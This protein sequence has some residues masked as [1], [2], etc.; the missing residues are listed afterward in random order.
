MIPMKKPIAALLVLIVLLAAASCAIIDTRSGA[1]VPKATTAAN[2]T[3]KT[4]T[5]THALG[6]VKVPYNPNKVVV[7]DL[8]VLDML[9][10][11][12]LGARVV[13]IPDITGDGYFAKYEDVQQLGTL[14]DIDTNA[15]KALKPELIVIGEA[16]H[17]KYEEL[18]EIAPVIYVSLDL[19]G[20]YTKALKANAFSIANIFGKALDTNAHLTELERRIDALAPGDKTALAV[21]LDGSAARLMDG[22]DGCV[23]F[24]REAGFAWPAEMADYESGGSNYL[25]TV[26]AVNPDYIFVVATEDAAAQK[27][28]FLASD[29]IKS[30]DAYQNSRII[31]LDPAAWHH[32]LGGITATKMMV[33]ELESL[34]KK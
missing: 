13:G 25:D 16:L 28:A 14:P 8:A 31:F 2:T 7:L 24:L 12:A 15:I 18:S 9:D 23:A 21:L 11:M 22:T 29:R 33:E 4:V 19:A 6:T 1:T 5:V 17:A 34:L 10:F 26:A 3:P 27:T 32:A 30:T 20:G